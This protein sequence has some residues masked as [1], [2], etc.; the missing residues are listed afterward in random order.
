MA[1]ATGDGRVCSASRSYDA[2]VAKANPARPSR[3][4]RTLT[5]SAR[6]RTRILDA[7][8]SV[9]NENGYA[10]TRIVDIAE[11]AQIQAPAIYYHFASRDEM[12]EEVI[13]TGQRRVIEYVTDALTGAS[14]LQPV[15][16]ILVAVAAHLEFVLTTSQYALASTRNF[17]QIPEEMRDRQ[18]VLRRQYGAVWRDLFEQAS[19]SGALDPDLDVHAARM[20]LIGALNWTV[21]WWDPARG[22]LADIISAAQQFTKDALA[23]PARVTAL[24]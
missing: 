23:R 10:A 17:G 1:D 4:I 5:K 11:A 22:D 24:R 13:E 18:I 16:R 14:G 7:A 19:E 12:I 2:C 3:P 8:A 15:D 20:L 21:E 6:T 9:L